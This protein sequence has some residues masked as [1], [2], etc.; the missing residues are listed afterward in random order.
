M[1]NFS[2]DHKAEVEIMDFVDY[3]MAQLIA[4]RL[5]TWLNDPKLSP[6]ADSG[7]SVMI[8]S[9]ANGATMF[10]CSSKLADLGELFP[11][12][13]ATMAK[14]YMYILL[15]FF[16]EVERKMAILDAIA[17]CRAACKHKALKSRKTK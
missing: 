9:N 1:S 7:M 12:H 5:H 6:L 2:F 17:E 15:P 13:A 16:P 3:N 4:R 8:S 10:L 11:T 14:T